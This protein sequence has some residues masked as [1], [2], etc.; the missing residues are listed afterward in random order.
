MRNFERAF[1]TGWRT[2]DVLDFY[3]LI[4]DQYDLY[5]GFTESLAWKTWL[6]KVADSNEK[7]RK[8]LRE[9]FPEVFSDIAR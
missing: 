1:D 8:T 4:E 3:G 2:I 7:D 5:G 9:Q 6:A